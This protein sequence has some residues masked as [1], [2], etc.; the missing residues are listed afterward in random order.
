MT[1]SNMFSKSQKLD[2]ELQ[3]EIALMIEALVKTGKSEA[4]DLA[5]KYGEHYL[6]LEEKISKNDY[7]K[8][9][10]ALDRADKRLT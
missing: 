2:K 10:A 7:T 9:D 4:L 8:E 3:L 6:K 1:L 5:E